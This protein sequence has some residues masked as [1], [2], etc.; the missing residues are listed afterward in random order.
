MIH[1]VQ[2]PHYEARLLD[3]GGNSPIATTS[4]SFSV[5]PHMKANS[6][7]VAE[8]FGTIYGFEAN[9]VFGAA[10]QYGAGVFLRGPGNDG[11]LWKNY[12]VKITA[13]TFFAH[14]HPIPVTGVGPA[15][16]STA[17][18]GNQLSDFYHLG[19]PV[20]ANDGNSLNFDELLKVKPFETS[21]ALRPICFGVVIYNDHNSSIGP[22]NGSYQYNVSVIREDVSVTQ[23][24][25]WD[26]TC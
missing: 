22:S 9:K 4:K 1:F 24:A 8:N 15:T 19:S 14:L 23:A 10:S 12:R 3:F 16:I 17:D 11:D 13:S 5:N 7:V 26:P 20:A 25:A 21:I 6:S 2:N 18:T